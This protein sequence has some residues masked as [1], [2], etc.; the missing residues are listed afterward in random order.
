MKELEA[1]FQEQST[2]HP[3]GRKQ[4]L[5]HEPET[6][7]HPILS[8]STVIEWKI[9]RR[10]GKIGKNSPE[11]IHLAI[12]VR[13]L[14]TLISVLLHIRANFRPA[15]FI[16]F[17][18]NFIFLCKK[19]A[20]LIIFRVIYAIRGT[21]WKLSARKK[22]KKRSRN[23]RYYGAGAINIFLRFEDRK[24]SLSFSCIYFFRVKKVGAFITIFY[25]VINRRG[26][27]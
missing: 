2:W 8:N 16:F 1:F 23:E 4:Y 24:A 7:F 6:V 5:T 13:T 20:I 26:N 27:E 17:L 19:G 22:N 9:W 11:D 14:T 15:Y 3:A 12:Y 25:C 10:P 18:F 21:M